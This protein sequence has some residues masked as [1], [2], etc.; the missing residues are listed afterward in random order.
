MLTYA[1]RA[2]CVR[3]M[4]RRWRR[5]AVPPEGLNVGSLAT[6]RAAKQSGC[7]TAAAAAS[8]QGACRH[9]SKSQG[10]CVRACAWGRVSMDATGG[11]G[12]RR[13]SAQQ[14]RVGVRDALR[15]GVPEDAAADCEPETAGWK[16]REVHT[17]AVQLAPDGRQA[18]ALGVGCDSIIARRALLAGCGAR[19]KCCSRTRRW[20]WRHD[21]L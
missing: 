2:R 10:A 16:G 9:G 12:V 4:T 3:P 14:L 1:P 15:I 17:A 13:T 21:A 8:K 7:H 11:A 18:L 5:A 20:A 19:R 6:G